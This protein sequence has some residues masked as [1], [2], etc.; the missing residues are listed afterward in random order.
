MNK[1]L[2]ALAL[3]G[4]SA[5]PVAMAQTANPVTLYGALRMDLEWVEVKGNNGVPSRTRIVD[6]PSLLGVR[7]TEDLGGGLKAVFQL[8]TGFTADD[9]SGTFANRNSRVGLEG[10]WGT[11]FMGRWDMPMKMAIG[12]VDPW[13][14]INKGDYTAANM[15]QG[16]FS[17]REP[18]VVQYWSPTWGGFGV[19]LAS[20]TTEGR[21]GS[22]KP[23]S[24]GGS[25]TFARG[26]LYFAYAYEEH[27]DQLGTTVTANA[28]EKGHSV[29][30]RFSIGA[31]RLAAIYG[32]YKKTGQAKDK[33][34]LLGGD[35]TMGKNMLVATFQKADAGSGECDVISVGW[36][37]NFSRR[38]NMMVSYADVD[39]NATMNC[40]FGAG[41]SLVP[42]SSTG[43]EPRGIG[44]GLRHYF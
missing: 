13:G 35:W 38:T 42:G 14:D 27:Q 37:Y 30:G 10:G 21:T 40:N 1:K 41:P 8:E 29:A 32:Q 44:I 28:E 22:A 39:N 16:N 18:N 11:I 25:V 34:Y 12:A 43:H 5:A 15:D 4:A 2:I 26:P 6:H 7:G 23:R 31:L 20:T 19:R 9:A 3:A 36:Q 24:V 17:R 33:S